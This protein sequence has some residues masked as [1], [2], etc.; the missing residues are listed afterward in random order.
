MAA[1]Q[2]SDES[3]DAVT[4]LEH[5]HQEVRSLFREFEKAQKPEFKSELARHIGEILSVHAR[6]EEQQFYPAVK[7]IPGLTDMVLE[8]LEEHRQ[9]KELIAE[10]DGMKPSDATFEPKMKVLMEDVDHHVDEEEK[11]M[12]PKVR[13]ALGKAELQDLG[14]SMRQLMHAS[15]G[16]AS[17]VSERTTEPVLD[18]SRTTRSK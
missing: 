3:L 4:L 13:Q 11:T 18:V 16:A 2:A 9:V 14:Q 12:F 17:A 8:G 15:K 5:D 10:L 7:S 6:A 1:R